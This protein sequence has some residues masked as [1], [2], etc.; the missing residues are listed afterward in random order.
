MTDELQYRN[1]HSGNKPIP[2]DKLLALKTSAVEPRMAN[3][4]DKPEYSI[5]PKFE[6]TESNT[7]AE[8]WWLRFERVAK[9]AGL[10]VFYKTTKVLEQV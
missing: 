5:I 9:L 6:G 7:D 10:L 4:L 3:H 8:L 1:L 2:P